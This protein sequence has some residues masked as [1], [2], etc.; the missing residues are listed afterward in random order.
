[1]NLF[2]NFTGDKKKG[3]SAIVNRIVRVS[4]GRN[5]STLYMH[6]FIKLFYSILLRMP[7]LCRTIKIQQFFM[8]GAII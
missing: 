1:M 7:R 2:I 4:G 8:I 6:L 3:I 5:L